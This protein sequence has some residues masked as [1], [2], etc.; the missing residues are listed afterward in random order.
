MSGQF[1]LWLGNPGTVNFL[2]TVGF[3]MF[4]DIIDHTYDREENFH[5]RLNLLHQ[6][7]DQLINKD[8]K[9]LFI[10]TNQRRLNN[11][12]LFYSHELQNFLTNQCHHYQNKINIK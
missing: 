4:D 12:K 9:Q 11:Q 7:I 10:E 2:R 6:S 8:L 1:G 5:L 3:D